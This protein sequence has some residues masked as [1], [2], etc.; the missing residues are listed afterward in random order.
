[1]PRLLPP[2]GAA[3][4]LRHQPELE[5]A[6]FRLYAALW[7]SPIVDPV[8]KELL[9]LRN[10]R[11]TDCGY[12]RSVRFAVARQAGR[13][14]AQVEAF[15]ADAD[16]AALTPR[17]RLAVRWADAFLADPASLAPAL[18]AP[19]LKAFTPAAIVELST[20]LALFMGFSKIAVALGPPPRDLPVSV[21]PVPAVPD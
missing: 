11:I 1:M 21:V 2:A 17:Q 9:R 6:F 20:A 16:A 5:R 3:S 7:A 19:M 14:E 10:A 18:R 15:N 13:G 12:C 8:T 4:V